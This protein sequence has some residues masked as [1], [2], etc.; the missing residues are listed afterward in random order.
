MQQ[1]LALPRPAGDVARLA[2]ALDLPH[3]AADRFPAL[4]LPRVLVGNAAAH[5][6]AAVP[7]EPAARVV[8]KDPALLAPHRQR[9]AGIDAEIVQRTVVML[10]RELGAHESVLW[11]F[12]GAVSHIF[13]AEHAEPQH[14]GWR[15]VGAEVGIE[16]A[17]DRL[18]QLVVIAALHLIV[19]GNGFI[20]QR[21]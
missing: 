12:L 2:I 16:F 20:F 3:V 15:Q 8:A 1:R 4:D 19:D 17:A 21:A 13:A 18:R 7:L 5:I 6:A 11:K 14:L 10:F 9:L